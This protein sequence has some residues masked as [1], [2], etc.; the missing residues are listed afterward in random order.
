MLKECLD[1]LKI[2]KDAVYIDCTLG[3][4]GHSHAILEKGGRVVG[5]D[6]DPDAIETS[7]KRLKE[8][9]DQGRMEIIQSNFR[10]LKDIPGKSR[11]LNGTGA[12]GILMDLGISSYQV[13]EATRGFAFGKDG[14]LNMRMDKGMNKEDV[15]A[16]DIVNNWNTEELANLFFQLG[17]ERGSR[18]I[19]QKIIQSRPLRTTEELRKAITDGIPSREHVK[20]L[21]RCFQALRIYVNDELEA[22]NEALM[23]AEKAL[24]LHG[25]L[26]ILS[27][28]SLEDRKVK[29]LFKTGSPRGSEKEGSLRDDD[30]G[31]EEDIDDASHSKGKISCWKILTKRPLTPTENEIKENSRS[32][33]AKLRAAELIDPLEKKRKKQKYPKKSTDED[34]F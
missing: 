19:A 30:D 22:L 32:R 12:S 13:D 29:Y 18:K 11:I 9:I 23:G 33:S 17:E 4:G 20:V 14:P 15:T 2:E 24:Q 21:A 5:L 10:H 28:H 3:G 8:Y 25:R 34:E 6:Q 16:E 26:V 31:D 1:Y 27:Y 7:S